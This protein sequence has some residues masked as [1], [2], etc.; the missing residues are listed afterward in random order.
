MI[1]R[2][3][4]IGIDARPLQAETRYRGI[5]KTL[6][7]ILQALSKLSRPCPIA[8]TFYVDSRLPRPKTLNLFPGATIEDVKSSD[9]RLGRYAQVFVTPFRAISP[10]RGSVDVLLQA[11]AALG[12]PTSV[13]TL[14]IFY[15]V[16]P[17]LFREQERQLEELP[18]VWKRYKREIGRHGGWAK[19]IRM[20]NSYKRAAGVVAISESS[21]KDL[22][23]YRKEIS[24]SKVR[25]IYLGS[26]DTPTTRAVSAK[27]RK[28]A[29]GRYLLYVGGIDVRKNVIALLDTYI[30]LKQTY[31]DLRLIVVGKEFELK[32]Q[33]E[34]IGW[35]KLIRDTPKAAKDVIISGFLRDGD[36]HYLYRNAIAFVFPSR[37]EGFG[38]PV[39]EAMQLGCPVVAY[40]NSS[41]PEVAGTAAL[42]VKDGADMLPSIAQLMESEELRHSLMEQGFIQAAKF[43]WERTSGEILSAL[44]EIAESQS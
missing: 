37:Y 16:I 29:R 7:N 8:F 15:D 19:Y 32:K 17:L 2:S 9:L 25:V 28:L 6:E 22:L 43:T 21:R 36:L 34:I 3:I 40:D 44:I 24:P 14:V 5:G 31:K 41:I 26:L 39:L 30:R 13:P 20:L 38:L 4:R 27:T 11:D 1:P 12:V 10:A 35:S 18:S 42:L 23:K 33:L